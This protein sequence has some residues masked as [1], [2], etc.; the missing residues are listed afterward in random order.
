MTAYRQQALACATL[1]SAGPGSP[2]D[3]RTVAPDAGKILLHNVYGWFERTQRGVYQLTADGEAALR[4]WPHA[5]VIHTSNALALPD[6][7]AFSQGEV[8]AT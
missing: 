2:R 8:S 1:L 5:S 3:L 4:R 7:L 6:T